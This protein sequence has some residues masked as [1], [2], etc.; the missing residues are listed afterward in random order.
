MVFSSYFKFDQPLAIT[1]MKMAVA[2]I[3]AVGGWFAYV[4]NTHFVHCVFLISTYKMPLGSLL[5]RS[6][7]GGVSFSFRSL[8]VQ[9]A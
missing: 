5:L 9:Y 1:L 4:Q 3:V 6:F 2:V 7:I 8:L